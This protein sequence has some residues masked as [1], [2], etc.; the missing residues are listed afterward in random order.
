MTTLISCESTGSLRFET[1]AQSSKLDEAP[2]SRSFHQRASFV[3]A[4]I[5][6][7]LACSDRG[8]RLRW[9]DQLADLGLTSLRLIGLAI[10]LE[11][12]FELDAPALA[13]IRSHCT[14]GALVRI[15]LR[16]EPQTTPSTWITEE[17]RVEA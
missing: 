1:H 6:E 3:I 9:N 14:V 13:S 12:Q 5:R 10:A 11:E 17:R 8:R 15:C 7:A 4:T 16:A 2:S